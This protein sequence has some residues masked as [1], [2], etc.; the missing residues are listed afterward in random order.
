M[1]NWLVGILSA[2]IIGAAVTFFIR[3]TP[4]HIYHALLDLQKARAAAHTQQ[5]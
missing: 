2:V 1:R 4:G 3:T 5:Q